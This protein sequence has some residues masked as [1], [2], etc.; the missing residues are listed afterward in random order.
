MP[1]SLPPTDFNHFLVRWLTFDMWIDRMC[2]DTTDPIALRT[3]SI[4]FAS[5][6]FRFPTDTKCV[7]MFPRV[8]ETNLGSSALVCL[9]RAIFI[10]FYFL[11]FPVAIRCELLF[12]FS[13]LVIVSWIFSFFFFFPLFCWYV[14]SLCGVRCTRW[15]HKPSVRLVSEISIAGT[16]EII[17]ESSWVSHSIAAAAAT[18]AAAAAAIVS[19]T[20]SSW[21]IVCCA[22]TCYLMTS[23]FFF[24]SFLPSV[25]FVDARS[26]PHSL[27]HSI[28]HRVRSARVWVCAVCRAVGVSVCC[29]WTTEHRTC[30]Q[31]VYIVYF[32]NRSCV[33]AHHRT[34]HHQSP[35]PIDQSGNALNFP[36]WTGVT[37]ESRNRMHF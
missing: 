3:L 32:S 2:T 26:L 15:K 37:I 21:P 23:V 14:R 4:V 9:F 12:A 35:P 1:S 6:Q 25:F 18:A 29:K 28:A 22:T 34:H 24:L 30:V 11:L 7:R 5:I 36:P 10:Y 31:I 8:R 17:N 16:F 20:S 19:Q 27:T 33:L 13:L